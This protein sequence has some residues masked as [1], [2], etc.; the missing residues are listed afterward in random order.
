MLRRLSS[1]LSPLA[2]A[3]EGITSG[4]PE[5]PCYTGA[6][7]PRPLAVLCNSMEASLPEGVGLW[8]YDDTHKPQPL[9]AQCESS[10]ASLPEGV[11][12]RCYTGA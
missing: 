3:S 2:A 9:A 4:V 7:G 1:G 6:R 10:E 12:V 5:V 11:G 8:Y